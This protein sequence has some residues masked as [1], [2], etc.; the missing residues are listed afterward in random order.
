MR[1]HVSYASTCSVSPSRTY[2][3]FSAALE[4]PITT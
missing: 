2:A 1:A 3:F 4:N